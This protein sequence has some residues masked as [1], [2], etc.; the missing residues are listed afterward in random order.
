MDKNLS[1]YFYETFNIIQIEVRSTLQKIFGSEGSLSYKMKEKAMVDPK[2]VKMH[3]PVF[4]R[5]YTDL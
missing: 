4:V 3:L 1:N 5:D 2:G